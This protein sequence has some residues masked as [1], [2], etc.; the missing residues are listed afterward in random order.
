MKNIVSHLLYEA[1]DIIGIKDLLWSPPREHT[2][3]EHE[4]HC[5]RGAPPLVAPDEA[6]HLQCQSLGGERERI[7]WKVH[8]GR[9]DLTQQRRRVRGVVL[10]WRSQ[11]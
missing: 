7:N 6:P 1:L 10:G 2:P 8:H 5:L 9:T 3:H 11:W 4:S